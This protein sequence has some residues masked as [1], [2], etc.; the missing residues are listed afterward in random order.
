M[1]Y[2]Q[3]ECDEW[4]VM[5]EIDHVLVIGI[6]TCMSMSMTT[7]RS[8][9]SCLY[10]LYDL[11]VIEER[12]VTYFTSLLNALVIEV[13]VVVGVTTSWR[14][15][16]GDHDD[17]D[18]GVMPVTMMIMEPWRWRSKRSKVM[19][20]ISCHYLIACDVYHVFASY[21]LRTTVVSK[22]IPYNN[23]KK[24]F[25][26]TVHR[27]EGSLFRST[28]WWSGVIDSNV[29]IQRVLTSLACTD[30][31]SEHGGPKGRAWVVW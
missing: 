21:L 6:T 17:G 5:Y 30:M 1:W 13:E 14:H 2:G 10:L 18:H 20:A 25:T 11:R 9:R 15:D 22:M 3:E 28:T 23:F 29:R 8:H 12:H 4:Y 16:D 19:M 27:C 26:L 31:A 24:V 7:G